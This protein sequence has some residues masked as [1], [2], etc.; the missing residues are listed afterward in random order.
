MSAPLRPLT[1]ADV[2]AVVA[3]EEAAFGAAA[4]N[5]RQVAGSLADP[6]AAGLLAPGAGFVLGR[7][8]GEEAELLRVAVH[9]A[10]RRAG[11]GRALLAGFEARCRAAGAR[12]AF[13]E[14]RED[15]APARAL[16]AAA[17]WALLGRRPGYYADG[18]AALVLERTLA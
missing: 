1:P 10:R 16:Y 18:A 3:L 8:L 7:L 6:H 4:W 13:L 5:P 12:R 17:G 11:L 15:N 2:D 9:P 14:V